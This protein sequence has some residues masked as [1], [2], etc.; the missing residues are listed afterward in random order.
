MSI[1]LKV[2]KTVLTVPRKND[3]VFAISVAGPDRGGLHLLLSSVLRGPIASLTFTPNNHTLLCSV[4]HTGDGPKFA[5]LS[6]T[7]P[8]CTILPCPSMM[9]VEKGE[10]SRMIGR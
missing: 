8:D 3:G 6:S 2:E 4:R 1:S 10:G 9:A 5:D 7:W